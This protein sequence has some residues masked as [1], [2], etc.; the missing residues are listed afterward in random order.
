MKNT[1]VVLSVVVIS[2]NQKDVLKRCLDSILAQRTT[3]PVEIIVSDDRSTDGTRE[4]LL[5]D[6]KET[7]KSTFFNSD[8]FEITYTLE[9]AA[10]NRINGLKYVT[11][12]YLI[13]T[14]GDDF[15]TS[16]DLFQAMVD[17]LESHLE[18]NLCC[19]NYCIVDENNIN[20]PHIP[21]N[22][23]YHF[24]KESILTAAEFVKEIGTVVNACVCARISDHF[25]YSN[26][27]GSTYDDNDITFRYLG[28]SK[29]ALINRC[30]FV[31]VNYHKSSCSSLTE[32]EKLYLFQGLSLI[33]LNPYLSGVL[34]NKYLTSIYKISKSVVMRYEI[35]ENIIKYFHF[36]EL[37]LFRA[38][39]NNPPIKD[40][41]RYL[42]IFI[43]SIILKILA[44]TSINHKILYK[45]MY[46]LAV[47]ME[48]ANNVII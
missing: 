42:R 13:H 2:H 48:I 38:L 4:M 10:L 15:F 45:R 28:N 44:H 35:P 30:D 14:D 34:I 27:N 31:Y 21:I 7:V 37:Y 3:F 43:L 20:A 22:K 16:T 29:V 46:K 8:K 11:G 6:Y 47:N 19:Q 1:P 40:W 25:D 39:S 12:K 41:L 32:R 24:Q 17:K 33:Q 36:S 9:R 18:C 5:D 23:S 26:L